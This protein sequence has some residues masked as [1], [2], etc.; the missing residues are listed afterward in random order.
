MT[1]EARKSAFKKS[2]TVGIPTVILCWIICWFFN[3]PYAAMDVTLVSCAAASGVSCFIT[4]MICG[5]IGYPITASMFK[6]AMKAKMENPTAETKPAPSIGTM[7][8]QMLFFKWSPKNWFCYLLVFSL[9]SSIFFGFGLPN[10]LALFIHTA[11]K[12]GTASQ[13][14]VTI[15]GGFQIGFAAQFCAYISN[16]FFVQLLQRKAM[17]AAAK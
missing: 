14:F 9:I 12:A 17:A 15:I 5:L 1:L 10:F 8:E 4:P 13:L 3:K 6:K 11:V 16:V 2:W 7:D